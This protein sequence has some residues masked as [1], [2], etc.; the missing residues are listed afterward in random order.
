MIDQSAR[1]FADPVDYETHGQYL[2]KPDDGSSVLSAYTFGFRDR[3][4]TDGS[5]AYPAEPGRYH[6]YLSIGCPWAQ[7]VAIAIELQG[8]GG[9]ISYSSVDDLRDG[10]G[11]AFR[12]RRGA[13]PVNDFSFLRQAYLATNPAFRGHVNVPTLWDR[14]TGRV[15]NNAD[16]DIF[17]DVVTRFRPWAGEVDLYP[18]ALAAEIDA[19]DADVH[20]A[21]NFGVYRA[22]LATDQ[23]EYVNIVD[24]AFATLDR[25]EARL[26]RQRYLFGDVITSSDVR[27]WVSLARF[28]IVY[29]PLFRVNLRRLVDY[30]NLWAYAR[31]LYTLPAFSARTEFETFKRNYF[32]G[33]PQLN[34][35]AII[36]A[37]PI[38]DWNAPQDRARLAKAR[39]RPKS[40]RSYPARTAVAAL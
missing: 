26:A 37:G 11:W 29:N 24:A 34:P 31:D 9:V 18:D 4:T 10:R 2:A 27:L 3:I 5:S 25:L 32:G 1:G 21:I 40:E 16:D 28:D 20:E 6:L 7:R 36:P 23:Q 30:P 19:L 33:I 12:E 15:V 8:L 13:D 35:S 38:I 39:I 17:H 14:N 22:G